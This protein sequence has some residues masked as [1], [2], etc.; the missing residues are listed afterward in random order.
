MRHG[1]DR[2]GVVGGDLDDEASGAAAPLWG[3]GDDLDDPLEP[4]GPETRAATRSQSATSAGSSSS[5]AT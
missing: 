2:G 4:V 5:A 3:F 1:V